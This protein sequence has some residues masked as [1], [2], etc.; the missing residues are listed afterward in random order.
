MSVAQVCTRNVITVSK[1]QK[2]SEAVRVMRQHQISDVVVVEK[3]NGKTIPVGILTD[4]DII[5]S[6]LGDI[7][8][9]NML[10]RNFMSRH[11]I[12]VPENAGIYE[13]IQIMEQNG[14]KRLPV[15]DQA[16]ALVGIV[17]ATDFFQILS[18]EFASLSKLSKRQYWRDKMVSST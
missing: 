6:S 13:A 4:H 18:R 14:I 5:N 15:V 2:V 7:S 10:I 9:S 1:E 3:R 16:G 12:T 11:L 8:P 17:C